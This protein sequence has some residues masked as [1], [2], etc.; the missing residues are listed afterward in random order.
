MGR[1]GGHPSLETNKLTVMVP[2]LS[3]EQMQNE[4]N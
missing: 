4:F 3:S 2:F 1:H